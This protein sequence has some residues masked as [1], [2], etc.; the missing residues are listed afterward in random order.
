MASHGFDD[1]PEGHGA[2]FGVSGGAVTVLFR[3]GGEEEKIPVAGGLEECQCGFEFVG[4][5]AFGPCVLIEG[6][7]DVMRLGEGWGQ[8]LAKAEGEDGLA[9]GQMGGDLADA[10]FAGCGTGIDL[11]FREVGGE[12]ADAVCGGG[13][14]GERVLAVQEAGVGV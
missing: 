2:A 3:D 14:N 12:G 6:L 5:V 13:E 4:L 10:P 7:D 1:G 9:V 8:R 11:G